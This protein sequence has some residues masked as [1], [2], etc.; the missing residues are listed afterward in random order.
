MIKD[1]NMN[2]YADPPDFDTDEGDPSEWAGNYGDDDQSWDDGSGDDL[3][4][5]GWEPE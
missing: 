1:A 4:V 3:D 5:L 2:I